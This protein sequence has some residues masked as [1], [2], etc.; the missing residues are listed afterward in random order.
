M[1]KKLAKVMV[2]LVAATV[3]M[4]GCGDTGKESGTNSDNES[5]KEVTSDVKNEQ[6]DIE[7]DSEQKESG[8]NTY[9]KYDDFTT[10]ERIV[11]TDIYFDRPTMRVDSEVGRII[12]DYMVTGYRITKNV[13]EYGIIVAANYEKPYTGD[14]DNILDMTY[15]EFLSIA[16]SVLTMPKWEVTAAE[17][18]TK[19]EKVTLENGIEAMRFE[20][21]NP[22]AADEEKFSPVFGYSCVFENVN[23]TIGFVL[24]ADTEELR[25]E[26]EETLKDIVYRMMNT[27]RIGKE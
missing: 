21:M 27:I 9:K 11:G 19:S 8:S 5:T 3:F 17:V 16:D 20:G 24:D 10:Y 26:Y 23:I 14:I 15:I 4:I 25:S 6:G 2:T 22:S 18:I 7:G 1:R 12:K 13:N